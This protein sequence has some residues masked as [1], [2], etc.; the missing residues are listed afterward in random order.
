MADMFVRLAVPIPIEINK[1]CVS[2]ENASTISL[3]TGGT[4]QDNNTIKYC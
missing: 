3:Y 1:S 4:K 2:G